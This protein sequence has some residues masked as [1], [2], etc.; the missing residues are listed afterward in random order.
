MT[1][2]PTAALPTTVM[3][4]SLFVESITVAVPVAGFAD[5]TTAELDLPDNAA[6]V[7]GVALILPSLLMSDGLIDIGV[8]A[9]V[10]TYSFVG[11]PP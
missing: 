2:E 9:A 4:D 7:A 3:V 5:N 6:A 11:T 1:A 10:A 8:E